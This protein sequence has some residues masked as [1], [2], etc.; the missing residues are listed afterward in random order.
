[1]FAERLATLKKY[2]AKFESYGGIHLGMISC[3]NYSH[4]PLSFIKTD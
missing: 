3:I 1:M 2:L 4:L